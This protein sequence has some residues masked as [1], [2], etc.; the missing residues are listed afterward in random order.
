MHYDTLS[1]SPG[2]SP[3]SE[4]DYVEWESPVGT[5]ILGGKALAEYGISE[6]Y[7]GERPSIEGE[8]FTTMPG[9]LKVYG[10]LKVS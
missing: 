3:P 7:T 2:G 6:W 5:F 1:Y 10:Q 9:T 8:W 4:G